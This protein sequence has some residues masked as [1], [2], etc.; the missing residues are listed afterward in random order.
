[1]SQQESI[2]EPAIIRAQGDEPK[3]RRCMACG[4]SFASEGWHNR[5]CNS[6]QKR[7]VP[8]DSVGVNGS[9]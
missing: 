7:S 4:K 2:D 6:C 1:M 9:R 8:Y 3:E 5:L